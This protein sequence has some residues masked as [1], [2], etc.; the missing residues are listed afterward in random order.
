MDLPYSGVTHEDHL[1]GPK[2]S[3]TVP[4]YIMHSLGDMKVLADAK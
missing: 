1:A 4:T 3:N 2:K